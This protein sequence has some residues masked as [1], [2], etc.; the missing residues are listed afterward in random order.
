M[1]VRLRLQFNRFP[2]DRVCIAIGFQAA[3]VS[4][5]TIGAIDRFARKDVPDTSQQRRTAKTVMSVIHTARAY[6]ESRR[7]EGGRSVA[8][9][10]EQ[11]DG[12]LE[13]VGVPSKTG[14]ASAH[15]RQKE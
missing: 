15:R 6:M 1:A 4:V 3:I 14:K 13:P 11:R 10:D 9:T 7:G 8:L 2:F 5:Q 12:A